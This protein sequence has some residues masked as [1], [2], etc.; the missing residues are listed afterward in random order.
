MAT[1]I[2]AYCT[3]RETPSLNFPHVLNARRDRSDPELGP[4]L[5]GLSGFI[6]E[7]GGGQMTQGLFHLLMHVERVQHHLSLSVEEDQKDAFAQWAQAA[8][9]ICFLPDGSVRA[10]NGRALLQPGGAPDPE[11][12]L[13]YPA[14]ALARKRSTG[15]QLEA[16]GISVPASLPPVI[17]SV[18]V[19]LRPPAEVAERAA[20]LFLVALRGESLAGQDALEVPELRKRFPTAFAGLSPQEA[21]FI[22]QSSPEQQEVINAVWRY[23]A[24]ALC[25]WALG[26]LPDLPPPKGVCDVATVAKVMLEDSLELAPG[27]SLRP[28]AEILD[29]LDLHYRLHW[30][31]REAGVQEQPPP[32]ELEPGVVVER[33]YALN[34]LV[35]FQGA[36]WDDVDT[37]T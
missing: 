23:E 37:P 4:H 5:S 20:A 8:N 24:L 3:L 26:R 16:L 35:R 22:E 25:L 1:L 31:V 18:E 19:R 2:N 32:A 21:S 34:W 30:A 9:A 27:A 11:A 29:A 14:E 12:Q 36:D 7:Q 13:P 33:H 28:T 15:R 17:A 6:F 10:P